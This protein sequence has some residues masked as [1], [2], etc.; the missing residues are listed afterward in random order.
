MNASKAKSPRALRSDL[1]RVDA[2]DIS[3][4]EYDELPDLS[5]DMLK[6]AVVNKGGRP[7]TTDPRLPEK[8]QSRRGD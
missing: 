4:R 8:G 7:R 1:A 2:H 6:R 3:A 5:D